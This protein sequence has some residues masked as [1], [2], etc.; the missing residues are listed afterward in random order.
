MR[1]TTFLLVLRP[2]WLD[3][4]VVLEEGFYSVRQMHSFVKEPSKFNQE[5]WS[6]KDV[7][8]RP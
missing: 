5:G 7:L 2:C 8:F 4:V 6:H 1:R 3:V